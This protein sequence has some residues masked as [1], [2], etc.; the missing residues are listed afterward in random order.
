MKIL[1]QE[2]EG[3]CCLSTEIVKRLCDNGFT[4]SMFNKNLFTTSEQFG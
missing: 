4:E 3:L 2:N 1:D